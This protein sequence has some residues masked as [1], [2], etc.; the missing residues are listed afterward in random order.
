M[1]AR[2]RGAVKRMGG[3]RNKYVSVGKQEG[4]RSL[5]RTERRERDYMRVDPKVRWCGHQDREKLGGIYNL[6]SYEA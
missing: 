5:G 2:T 1:E 4:K 3:M 6:L